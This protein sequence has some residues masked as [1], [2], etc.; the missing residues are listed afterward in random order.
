[1]GLTQ[2]ILVF[3]SLLVVALVATT[4]LFTTV[5]ADRLA[6][7]TITQALSDT[8]GVWETFQADRFKE[9]KLGVRVL[10]NDPGFKALVA[11]QEDP[12]VRQT[13]VLNTLRERR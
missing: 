8:R 11:N 4:L 3:V 1:M 5:Q 13:T 2:K 10:S 6:H 9:L 12:A 7:A